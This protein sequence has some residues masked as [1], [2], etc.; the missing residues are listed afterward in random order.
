MLE[1]Q[2]MLPSIYLSVKQFAEILQY[3]PSEGYLKVQLLQSVF[4]RLVDLENLWPVIDQLY[5]E[6]EVREVYID[7]NIV[8]PHRIHLIYHVVKVLHRLGIL[9]VYDPMYPDREY[10]LDLRRWDE[11]EMA[12]ILIVFA[13]AEPG[14][15]WIGEK[16]RWSKYDE[17]V[18][19]WCLPHKW[20]LE[21]SRD[22]EYG[23]QTHGWLTLKY[24]SYG[25]DC[26]A[27]MA[28]RKLLRKRTLVGMKRSL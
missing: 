9:N 8:G 3:F 10:K 14:E 18:P 13:V 20:T 4:S 19:G 26:L 22:G 17:C 7:D 2:I 6:D 23:P 27:N 11:R 28:A 24:T 5:D 1:L 12:K 21:D 16:F 25:K 15:N